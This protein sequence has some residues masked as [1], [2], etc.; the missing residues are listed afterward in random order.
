MCLLLVSGVWR[1]S[2]GKARNDLLFALMDE[3]RQPDADIGGLFS[4]A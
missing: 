4:S 2:G 1:D 3:M